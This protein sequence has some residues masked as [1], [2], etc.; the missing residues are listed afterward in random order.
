MYHSPKRLET[1][2]GALPTSERK[3]ADESKYLIQSLYS[4][5]TANISP[6]VKASDSV[7]ITSKNHL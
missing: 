4:T 6:N 1:A 2:V 3:L 7:T 5:P